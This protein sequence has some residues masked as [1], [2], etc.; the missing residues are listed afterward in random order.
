LPLLPPQTPRTGRP[1]VDHRRI[2]SGILC[3]LRAGAPWRDLPER[4]GPWP[5]VNSC[6]QRWRAVGIWDR[7]FA[8]IQRLLDT[9]ADA[10]LL[11]QQ[12]AP[13]FVILLGV[14]VADH[15]HGGAAHRNPM[16]L[17]MM[18]GLPMR[19]YATRMRRSS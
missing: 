12:R 15:P 2:L 10:A 18:V 11:Q 8:V 7:L 14:Q 3:I 5:T 17:L 4:Y 6:F 16:V 13:L 9:D 19:R 1:A